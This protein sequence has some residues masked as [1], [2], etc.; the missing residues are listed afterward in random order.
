MGTANRFGEFCGRAAAWAFVGVGGV[1]AYEVVM[2]YVF[3]AP[4][5]WAEEIARMVQIWASY[6]AAGFILAQRRMIRVTVVTD[7]LPPRP[8]RWA[9]GF[10][11]L[12]IVGFC[13]VAVW[14]GAEVAIESIDIGRAS[15]T[16]LGLPQWATE[17]AIPVGFGLLLTQA[18][19]QLI[20]LVRPTDGR[21]E[22]NH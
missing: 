1:L 10:S 17:F 7:R 2:R 6:L 14:Y 12:W 13:L 11:L 19:I 15:S 4:T 9:E 20:D 21:E 18:L 16:M 8:K 22:P 3:G 5:I